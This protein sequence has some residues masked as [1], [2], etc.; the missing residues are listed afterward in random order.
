MKEQQA[1]E[2]ELLEQIY[3]IG[4]LRMNFIIAQ[5]FKLPGQRSS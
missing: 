2:T 4:L 1:N 3:Q 5:C